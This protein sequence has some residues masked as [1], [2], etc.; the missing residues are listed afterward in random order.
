MA[1]LKNRFVQA[2]L[3][4]LLLS[5]ILYAT[6]AA[7]TASNRYVLP[8]VQRLQINDSSGAITV[9]AGI[10]GQRI[11]VWGCT[12]ATVSATTIEFKSGTTTLTGP[13]SISAIQVDAQA[14]GG[15]V[16]PWLETNAGDPLTINLGGTVQICGQVLWT[17]Q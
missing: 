4:L 15:T 9:V 11:Q 12:L 17:Q 16:I 14:S 8:T 2:S 6:N 10:A 3:C 13:M 7:T 1:W 5:S